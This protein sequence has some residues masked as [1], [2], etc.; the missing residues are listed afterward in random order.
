M[1]N[2]IDM[3]TEAVTSQNS[4]SPEIQ[5]LI[6]TSLTLDMDDFLKPD[7]EIQKQL[8]FSSGSSSF[9]RSELEFCD[10]D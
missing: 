4:L 10:R 8:S 9:Y 3:N 6:P 5:F 7:W 1:T 2:P